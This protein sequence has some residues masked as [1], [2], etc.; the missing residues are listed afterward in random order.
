M[1][2]KIDCLSG[3]EIDENLIVNN[4]IEIKDIVEKF[5][6][7]KKG[8][9]TDVF[10]ENNKRY[11]L[12]EGKYGQYLESEDYENDQLR[13]PLS[14]EIK[15][16]LS[17]NTI[18]LSNGILK[19]NDILNKQDEEEKELIT[20]AGKCEKCGNDFAIKTGRF[21]KFLACLGYPKCQNIKKIT[22]KKK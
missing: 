10:T 6:E 11:L 2:V 7:S 9:K 3:L 22:K 5:L 14:K 4:Q 15:S 1:I 13:K 20:N 18:K 17:K 19:L 8:I 16:K 12:K 21:G